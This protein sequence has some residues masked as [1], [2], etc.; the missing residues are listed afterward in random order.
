MRRFSSTRLSG[1]LI[2]CLVLA[3]AGA[4]PASA[5][6]IVTPYP[7]VRAEAGQTSTFNLQIYSDERE[8]V[9]LDVTDAPD[10]WNTTF[11]GDGQEIEAIYADPGQA[12]EAQLDVEVPDDVEPG[13]YDVTVSA[14]AGSGDDTLDLGLRVVEQTAD[15]FELT[16][17]FE[18]LRGAT[19]DTFR[20]DLTLSNRSGQEG[21][22]ALAAAGPQGW[23]VSASPSTEQQAATVTV[24]A[25][26]QSTINVEADPPDGVTAGTYEIG[27][28]ATGEG[29]TLQSA[30]TVEI[31]GTSSMTLST[32]DERLNASGTA[33][34][35]GT[36]TVTVTND[37]N[38]P[39]QGV[40]LSASPPSNWD[41]TFDPSTFD[42]IPA[43][44]SAQAIARITPSGDAI[45]GDYV[46][47]IDASTE[48][49]EDSMELRYT[50]ETSGWWGLVGI[51]VIVAAVGGLFWVYR[52]YGRR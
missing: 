16:T 49:G 34:D 8:P 5:A 3:I 23:N 2:V 25:G 9:E 20:F 38:A 22:F 33:G 11:R 24:D 10:G 4:S 32:A 14:D 40:D 47:T 7:T 36:V 13:T 43:G 29:T 44:Q 41:V 21:T 15:A 39:L 26:G 52:R 45:A 31:T 37:G 18:T 19:D 51:L 30:L 17:D 46:V 50:V 27:V 12:V 35:T 28:E 6:E 48:G 42:N 1:A